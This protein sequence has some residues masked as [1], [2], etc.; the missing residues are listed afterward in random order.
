MKKELMIKAETNFHGISHNS[1]HKCTQQSLGVE[2]ADLVMAMKQISLCNLE[3]CPRL[4]TLFRIKEIYLYLRHNSTLAVA[5]PSVASVSR[6]VLPDENLP[7]NPTL[8]NPNEK[9]FLKFRVLCK[10][11]MKAF[12]EAYQL[13]LRIRLSPSAFMFAF[14]LNCS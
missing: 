7:V 11:L 5:L 8:S 3:F 9:K 12:A 13:Q 10:A 2:P 6:Q 14:L 1:A 4:T